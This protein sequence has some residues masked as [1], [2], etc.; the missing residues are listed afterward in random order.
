MN[1]QVSHLFFQ[2]MYRIIAL[3]C[4]LT[5][6]GFNISE[7]YESEVGKEAKLDETDT[8]RQV[9]YF[10]MAVSN[11]WEYKVTVAPDSYFF[12]LNRQFVDQSQ[13]IVQKIF[14]KVATQGAWNLSFT[15]TERQDD[16][17]AL[18]TSF[19]LSV[20]EDE[21]GV[22]LGS[23]EVYLD[24]HPKL[25]NFRV[26]TEDSRGFTFPFCVRYMDDSLAYR[27][28]GAAATD[29]YFTISPDL[30]ETYVVS[31]PAGTFQGCVKQSMRM[32]P[33]KAM[34]EDERFLFDII[35]GDD[36]LQK[37]W[38]TESYFAAGVGL[39]KQQQI[40]VDGK[41]LNTMELVSYSIVK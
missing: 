14:V 8:P 37:G 7:S 6:I 19:K 30:S 36:P 13:T 1:C 4:V 32:R 18:D 25:V 12:N 20:L 10:P 29:A 40:A 24:E 21:L 26:M 11:K 38:N 23:N 2:R 39:V 28:P 34:S 35:G 41:V 16:P 5:F 33:G 27:L 17:F 3:C 22:F 15:I 9:D 31:V